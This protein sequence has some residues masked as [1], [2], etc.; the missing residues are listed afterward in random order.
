MKF[1]SS[2]MPPLQ[3]VLF[4][5]TSEFL[6]LV[7]LKGA[8]NWGRYSSRSCQT[9]EKIAYSSTSVSLIQSWDLW[10]FCSWKMNGAIAG[11]CD[12]IV[13]LIKLTV[14][15][16]INACRVSVPFA[17][18]SNKTSCFIYCVCSVVVFAWI[19]LAC[20]YKNADCY[21]AVSNIDFATR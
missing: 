2:E 17:F 12:H 18:H 6:T 13:D 14:L 15:T 20:Q 7:Q 9:V 21:N 8:P 16:K 3:Y 4:V 11:S 5:Q 10:Q 19:L 1:V